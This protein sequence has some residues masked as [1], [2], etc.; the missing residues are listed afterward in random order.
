MSACLLIGRN[1]CKLP[2]THCGL[3]PETRESI[4]AFGSS[5][6]TTRDKWELW[7][8][9]NTMLRSAGRMLKTKVGQVK[10]FSFGSLRAPLR[11]NQWVKC[12]NFSRAPDDVFKLCFMFDPKVPTA[13]VNAHLLWNT[14]IRRS[15]SFI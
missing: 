14:T 6:C 13:K 2:H 11:S 1:V 15:N 8:C 4:G 10:L 7:C 3:L 5:L 9:M 12:Q